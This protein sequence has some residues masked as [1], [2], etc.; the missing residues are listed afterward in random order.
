MQEKTMTTDNI[1]RA[2][3]LSLPRLKISIGRLGAIEMNYPTKLPP[4]SE[5]V[6]VAAL[7]GL[8]YAAPDPALFAEVVEA[9]RLTTDRLEEVVIHADTSQADPGYVPAMQRLIAANRAVL[10]KIGGAK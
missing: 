3:A 5:W 4:K 1:R 6:N 9:L 8:P 2:D 7:D 10:A